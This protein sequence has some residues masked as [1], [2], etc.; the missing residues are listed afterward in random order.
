VANSETDIEEL[1]KL[2]QEA[3]ERRAQ[4]DKDRSAASQAEAHQ[5]A[6]ESVEPEAESPITA[7]PG[8]AGGGAEASLVSPGLTE[9]FET[10]LEELEE[11]ASERPALALLTAF[12]L[13][14]IVGQLFSRR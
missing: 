4:R 12:S 13:G 7:D 9:Q 6:G 3:S 2:Q 5:A 14:V 8:S 1:Q 11:A 10:M